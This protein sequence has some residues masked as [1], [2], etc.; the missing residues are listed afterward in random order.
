MTGVASVN[1]SCIVAG[2]VATRRVLLFLE[3][4]VLFHLMQNKAK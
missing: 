2:R 1:V 4:L 3:N